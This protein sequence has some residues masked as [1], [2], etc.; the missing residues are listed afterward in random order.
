MAT[1]QLPYTASQVFIDPGC[2]DRLQLH[3]QKL[4]SQTGLHDVKSTGEIKQYYFLWLPCFCVR[5]ELWQSLSHAL[6][7]I[8]TPPPCF[9]LYTLCSQTTISVSAGS[10]AANLM[11][12]TKTTL[13]ICLNGG[14]LLHMS[15]SHRGIT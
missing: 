9:L 2:S 6:P 5:E 10:R 8:L 13:A 14:T 7:F 4:F 1:E 15:I 11:N 12:F 3:F